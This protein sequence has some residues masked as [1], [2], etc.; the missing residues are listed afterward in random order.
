MG[1]MNFV[2]KEITKKGK[3]FLMRYS[4]TKAFL[5]NDDDDDDRVYMTLLLIAR[6]N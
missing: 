2:F 5:S 4:H 1:N 3:M 6:Q